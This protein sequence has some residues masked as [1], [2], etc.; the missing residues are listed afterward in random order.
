[1]KKLRIFE[2]KFCFAETNQ[3]KFLNIFLQN[4]ALNDIEALILGCTHY[5]LIK[6]QIEQYNQE[7]V[8]V[9]DNSEI[10]AKA[11]GNYLALSALE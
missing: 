1:M 3:V 8:F 5:P 2:R 11:L 4:L 9:G 7:K 10:A 6:T